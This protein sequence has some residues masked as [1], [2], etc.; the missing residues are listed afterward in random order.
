MKKVFFTIAFIAALSLFGQIA[1]ADGTDI[2][3]RTC[4]K[5]HGADGNG[6]KWAP[7]F[8]DNPFITDR[9][10]DEISAVIRDGRSKFASR[11]DKGR[12]LLQGMFR[13]KLTET[14]VA[15]IAS[16]LKALYRNESISAS[17]MSENIRSEGEAEDLAKDS[18]EEKIEAPAK[19][20]A[21]Y[22]PIKNLLKMDVVD[23]KLMGHTGSVSSV[24]FS[25]DGQTLASGSIDNS[26]GL[27]DVAT[28]SKLRIFEDSRNFVRSVVFS[29]DGKIL[30][31]STDK[32]I[33]L[34]DLATGKKLK[35][36][37]GHRDDVWS[38]A[39]SPDG[40][41]LASGSQDETIGL[42][43]V[44]TGSMIKT[45]ESHKAPILSVAFSP[46]G[47]M[48]ASG[49]MNRAVDIW[50]VA[51][52]ANL[53]TFK[54]DNEW[55]KSVAF[56]PDSRTLLILNSTTIGLVDV[57]TWSRLKIF[58]RF[59]VIAV[60]VS[61]DGKTLASGDNDGNI[62]LW[63]LATGGMIKAFKG[64]TGTVNSV[65][66]SPDGKT[67]AS[68]G[69]DK[70]V[71]LWNQGSYFTVSNLKS[72]FSESI[73]IEKNTKLK[74]LFRPKGEFEKTKEYEERI[75]DAKAEEMAIKREYEER[76]KE[77]EERA[78]KELEEGRSKLY[79]VSL[80]A[81]LGR[82][83]ADK[84]AFEA[85]ILG[86]RVLI[87]ISVEKAAEIS[88]RKDNISI[89]G[90][91]RYFDETKAELVNPFLVDTV[92]KERF[93]FGRHTDAVMTASSR[94]APP[95]LKIASIKLIEPSGNGILEAG[96]K[97]RLLILLRNASKGTALGVRLTFEAGKALKGLRLNEKV[98]IGQINPNEE[99]TVE[100]D[101][102]G[103]DDIESADLNLKAK[104]IETSGFDS[105]PVIIAF[106]TKAL[107]P[108]L[109]QVAKVDI[110][111]TDG[112]RVITKG[113]EAKVTLM[114]Q[115]AGQGASRDVVVTLRP[116]DAEI[117]MFGDST[118]KIGML[119][120]GES[121]KAVF[122]VAV[123][124]RY[125]GPKELPLHVIVKEGRERFSVKP[126]IK[127]ALNEEAPDV[128]VVKVE[129]R[130]LPT[131]KVEDID[132]INTPPAF[133]Q[134][135]KI[136][137][138]QD[139]AIVIGVERYRKL[140][141]AEFA[142]NDA[143]AVKGYLKAMGFSE[144]N[145]K[146]LVDEEATLSGINSSVGTW[147]PN[148]IKKESRV[149]IYYSGHGSPDP[150]TGEAYLMPHDG[151]PNYLADTGYSLK[152]LY[153]SLAKLDAAEVAVVLDSCFSGTGG[154]SV[155]AKGARPMVVFVDEGVLAS[156]NL[157]ILSS[158]Q[159]A[160][161]STSYAEK[162]HG[163]FTY[164]FLKAV[165]E[166]KKDIGEIY[167]YIKPL[168]EDEARAQNVEQSPSL[169]PGPEEVKARFGLRR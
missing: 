108:P 14:E 164:Y 43:D 46:D 15:E 72:N 131:A 20:E 140:P 26:I 156:K 62:G 117:R 95:E 161:I 112:R 23:D 16:Y 152:K 11:Y 50:D 55:V 48:L 98:Y 28:R 159:G 113:K 70:T 101:I 60:A 150:A 18:L 163:L 91:I 132:D 124:S 9:S 41:M 122:S 53:K 138:D 19:N 13:Q 157:A 125:N 34:W 100:V 130:A 8:K 81:S 61:P 7:G 51:T 162:E 77:A 21:I 94:K 63:N 5:C 123:T 47:K 167:S 3:E 86:S 139:V 56:S 64:H 146:F 115:N 89:Q 1:W 148:R 104:L 151:D 105:Q 40:Q 109:L 158:T 37:E 71:G 58:K 160:Q 147:L 45:L 30:A 90:Q 97:G 57:S 99:K 76:L 69:A 118:F 154:R 31:G 52:W 126:D 121:K 127:F 145:I 88:K 87:N 137:G 12:Y 75:R 85:D 67:L 32:T 25:P 17:K 135:Q 84:E 168:V 79:P 102:S 82:Y 166:G 73:E 33:I 66:F 38:V 165:K 116:D 83:D 42:W 65:A 39:F 10:I 68:G 110:E 49:D 129:A 111:D 136:M 119:L 44:A 103:L 29:P 59:E 35:T 120:P 153:D 93:A 155:I 6:S 142:Y 22:I 134:E 54:S 36:L 74:E 107:V 27:W 128:R 144:R 143:K 114:V 2:Y 133:S 141:K 149:F 78:E 106:K 80:K 24:A 96:E 169:K 4:K 92:T